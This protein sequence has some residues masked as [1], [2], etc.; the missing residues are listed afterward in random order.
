MGNHFHLAVDTPEAN[1]SDGMRYL[2][3]EYAQWFNMVNDREGALF[4]R[5]FWAEM[6]DTDA[7]LYE[8]CRYIVLNPVR[9]GICRAPEDWPWSSYSGTIGLTPPP[10]FLTVED[11]LAWFGGAERGGVRY[12]QF[13][14]EGLI[15]ARRA[16]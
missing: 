4:E 13:V 14:G 11:V 12:A 1:L 8:V 15:D 6:A 10:S 3:G 5:R 16:A 9:A 7:Y 2:K